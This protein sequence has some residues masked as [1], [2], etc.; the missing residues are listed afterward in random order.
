MIIYECNFLFHGEEPVIGSLLSQAIS[1]WG[2][3]N[4]LI[5]NLENTLDN[6]LL[7]INDGKIISCCFP[8]D[9]LDIWK[10]KELFVV[11]P[12]FLMFWEKNLVLYK[13]FADIEYMSL[14][15]CQ[16][17]SKPFAVRFTSYMSIA[18]WITIFL[19]KSMSVWSM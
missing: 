13:R 10:I 8:I 2:H 11:L 5:K 1:C 17:S 14:Q 16:W 9:D 7:D 15:V 3:F 18:F 6:S 12:H 19:I 4:L